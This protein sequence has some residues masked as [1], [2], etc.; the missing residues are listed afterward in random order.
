MRPGSREN[1]EQ[2]ACDN[3]PAPRSGVHSI[4]QRA[5][6]FATPHAYTP[7]AFS[8]SRTTLCFVPREH[9]DKCKESS[10]CST[11]VHNSSRSPCATFRLACKRRP[12]PDSLLD[13]QR[14]VPAQL[15]CSTGC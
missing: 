8:P 14:F 15:Y 7:A 1:Q 9:L 5:P 3:F 11:L 13:L 6:N 2:Y 4:L 12:P 10:R